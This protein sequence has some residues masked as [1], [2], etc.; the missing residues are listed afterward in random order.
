MLVGTPK[1]RSYS[2]NQLMDMLTEAELIDI[3]RIPF[4]GPNNSGIIKGIVS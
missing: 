4:D 2:E 3:Q 1:G